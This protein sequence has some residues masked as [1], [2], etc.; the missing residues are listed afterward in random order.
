MITNRRAASP[1]FSIFSNHKSDCLLLLI[2]LKIGY[3]LYILCE[4]GASPG[5]GENGIHIG[6]FLA[7]LKHGVYLAKE[8]ALQKFPL[9]R[10]SSPDTFS[11]NSS[12]S[13]G[14]CN[15]HFISNEPLAIIFKSVFDADA[16]G[17]TEVC[18]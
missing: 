15:L 6:P 8:V 2:S 16:S 1:P 9:L 14:Y 11:D 18:S 5:S 13:I 17:E 4:Y 3:V 10:I 12:I 7:H